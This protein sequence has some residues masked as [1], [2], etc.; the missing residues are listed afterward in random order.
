[1]LHQQ[2]GRR[3]GLIPVFLSQF[4]SF[5]VIWVPSPQNG[6]AHIYDRSFSLNYSNLEN[7]SKICLQHAPLCS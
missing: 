7:H 2:A 5:C 3:G 1:M 6:V 4:I